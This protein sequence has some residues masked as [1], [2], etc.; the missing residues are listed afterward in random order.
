[1]SQFCLCYR[2]FGKD[3]FFANI[4]FIFK[5]YRFLNIIDPSHPDMM[6]KV[7]LYKIII[8]TVLM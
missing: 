1:M 3:H 6:T 5:E 7:T 4:V 8:S 2:K